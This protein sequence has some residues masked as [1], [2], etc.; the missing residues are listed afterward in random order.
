VD[1]L[2]LVEDRQERPDTTPASYGLLWVQRMKE[3]Q[4]YAQAAIAVA[5]QQQEHYANL[6]REPTP[7]Y[8]VGDKVWLNLKNIHT[9]RPCKKLDWIHGKYTVTRTFEG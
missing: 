1:P 5:Q 2:G 3:A 4:N 7:T 9:A 6:R 8:R